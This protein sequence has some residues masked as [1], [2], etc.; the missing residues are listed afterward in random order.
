M[1]YVT[2]EITFEIIVK[3]WVRMCA[4]TGLIYCYHLFFAMYG[5]DQFTDL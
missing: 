1:F 3:R 4:I 2:P 5:V